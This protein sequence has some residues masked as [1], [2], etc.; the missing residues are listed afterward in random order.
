M[1]PDAV[2][3][4]IELNQEFVGFLQ[5]EIQDRR[6]HTIH[7]SARDV[8]DVLWKL[9]HRRADYIISGIPYST[10]PDDDRTHITQESRE[11]LQPGG[12]LIMYQFT[13]AVSPYLKTSF[14]TVRK[15]FQW[16]NIL[17]A[18]IFYCTP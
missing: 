15:T 1:R 3:V 16:L 10:I 7:A 5:D 11:L 13:D 4:A 6:L 9:G 12:A 17:P 2:L 8:R 18:R 14:R